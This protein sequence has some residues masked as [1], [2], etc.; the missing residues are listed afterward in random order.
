MARIHADG[1]TIRI[2][3]REAGGG[4]YPGLPALL[5]GRP[6]PSAPVTGRRQTEFGAAAV[7]Q[8]MRHTGGDSGRL[9]LVKP[10]ELYRSAKLAK[11]A[12]KL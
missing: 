11:A 4:A 1:E 6:R 2:S 10:H 9:F 8:Y 12:G 7:M 5:R 3:R